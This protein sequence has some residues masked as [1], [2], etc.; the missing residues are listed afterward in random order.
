MTKNESTM[1]REK[2]WIYFS[3]MTET[4]NHRHGWKCIKCIKSLQWHHTSS[5]DHPKLRPTSALDHVL[6]SHTLYFIM[7]EVRNQAET[8][9]LL[10]DCCRWT[11]FRCYTA[12]RRTVS[13]SLLHM[14]LMIIHCSS[15]FALKRCTPVQRSRFHLKLLC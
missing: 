6:F 9:P 10:I 8:R 14:P 3:G 1:V 4:F 5:W 12:G 13:N 15:I 11:Q 2:C 7:T